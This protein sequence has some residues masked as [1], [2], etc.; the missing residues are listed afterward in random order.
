MASGAISRRQLLRW[1]ALGGVVVLGG[2]VALFE[3]VDHSVL[4][5]HQQLVTLLGDCEVSVPSMSFS[6]LGPSESGT[7]F[8]RARNQTVGYTIAYP[9]GHVRGDALPLIV[10]LHA[11]GAN[12]TNAL[13]GMSLAQ[14]LALR[15]DGQPLAPMAMVAADG[16]GGYWNPHPGDNPMAMVVDELIPIC[17]GRGL[18]QLPQKIGTMGISMGG[19]GAVL[20]AEKVPE[21]VSAVAAISPA[22]WTSYP[23]ARAANAGAYASAQ[24]F[25]SNDAV[26]HAG[27]LAGIPLRIAS[28]EEDPF[29]AGVEALARALPAGAT[30][31]FSKG[32]HT[33]SFFTAQEPPSLAF[34][35][36]HL[37]E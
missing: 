26:T 15:A 7:F 17:Q 25:V 10:V 27:A 12:H 16:G 33:P 29:H 9:P 28:G 30:V 8:S 19:Y 31:H 37:S 23:E 1:S 20:L 5:G 24:D 14:A 6:P 4:P 21:M 18:G 32:C 35:A 3:L 2:G 13:S 22:I 11:F 36:A 34:L